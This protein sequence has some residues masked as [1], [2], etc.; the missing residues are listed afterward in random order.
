[1]KKLLIMIFA[2]L[3]ASFSFALDTSVE[4]VNK[5]VKA[6][7]SGKANPVKAEME[8]QNRG[9]K[10][11]DVYKSFLYSLKNP[12]YNKKQR[13]ENAEKWFKRLKK[14]GYSK[15]VL[16]D[17][18]R[19]INDLKAGAKTTDLLKQFNDT[20]AKFENS[21]KNE[22]LDHH[23][24]IINA[25]DYLLKLYDISEKISESAVY[26]AEIKAGIDKKAETAFWEFNAKDEWF[27]L[28]CLD[29]YKAYYSFIYSLTNKTYPDINQR[30]DNAVKWYARLDK[31]Y[32]ADPIIETLCGE[33][34]EDA[35]LKLI[36]LQMQAALSPEKR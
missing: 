21:F 18:R 33:L 6:R 17:A 28:E 1:M 27:T 12:S 29:S 19:K 15:A 8:S 4:N 16:K 34:R 9:N 10:Q 14:N 35:K 26:S 13:I 3:L 31:T 11:E 32:D 30:A 2:V 20:Y 22:N 5:E 25:A 24:R 36:D 23:R 7:Q